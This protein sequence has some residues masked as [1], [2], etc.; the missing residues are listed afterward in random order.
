DSWHYWEVRE[1]PLK[2][3]LGC[4]YVFDSDNAILFQF[5][6]SIHKKHWVA[7]RKDILNC[8]DVQFRHVNK[9]LYP[10]M[11]PFLAWAS[12]KQEELLAF[13]R[14]M[15]ELETPSRDEKAIAS[16][17]DLLE[18]QTSDIAKLKRV[19]APGFGPHLIL[20]FDLP[21]SKKRGQL[22]GLAHSD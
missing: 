7:M 6:D 18:E 15:V 1:M 17:A 19:K 11:D 13:L 16:F 4:R 22:L 14:A 20:E 21:G 10:P 12:S 8:D 3:G 2:M 5:Q 9:L